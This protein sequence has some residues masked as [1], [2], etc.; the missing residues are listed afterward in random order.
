MATGGVSPELKAAFDS[1]DMPKDLLPMMWLGI[2]SIYHNTTAMQADINKLELKTRE[3]VDTVQSHDIDI[4]ELQLQ[5]NALQI[6]MKRSG[7]VQSHLVDEIESLKSRSMSDN[8]IFRF[9]PTA[10]DYNEVKDET[11]TALVRAFIKN[12]LGIQT[13]IYVQSSHRLGKAITGTQRPIIARIPQAA[14][15]ALILQNAPR[16]RN[17]K[18]GIHSQL[19]A[20]TVE[21]RQLILPD[22]KELKKDIRNKAVLTQDKMYVKNKVQTQYLKPSLPSQPLSDTSPCKISES[23]DKKDSGSVFR[24]YCARIGD[25][26]DIAKVRQYLMYNVPDVSKATHI[27]YAYRLETRGKIIENFDSDRDWGIGMHF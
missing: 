9:D 2:K 24:G 5:I 15:R 1:D 13:D 25:L 14:Q 6:D 10:T 26:D 4:T 11:C 18:H 12:V 7:I 19:P 20:S 8:L 21:R 16:L 27:I 22:Y 17:T 23:K 3:L